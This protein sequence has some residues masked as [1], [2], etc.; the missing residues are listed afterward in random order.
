M[1]WVNNGNY[2]WLQL[3]YDKLCGLNNF[4]FSCSYNVR[5]FLRILHRVNRHVLHP[6]MVHVQT[7]YIHVLPDSSHRDDSYYPTGNVLSTMNRYQN[8]W[9]I[10]E[11]QYQYI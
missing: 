8:P 1:K 6:S 2:F 5:T 3:L 11:I 10:H 4:N 9:L 7:F